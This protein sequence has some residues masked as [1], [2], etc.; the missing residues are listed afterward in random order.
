MAQ[1]LVTALLVAAVTARTAAL[2]RQG[3]K[4][5]RYNNTQALGV[6]DSTSITGSSGA[7]VRL[8]HLGDALSLRLQG[9]WTPRHG[10]NFVLHCGCH[11]DD[12]LFL[13]VDDHM[14][15][16]TQ[17]WTGWQGPAR[18]PA[19]IPLAADEPVYVRAHL[20]R[21]R[22]RPLVPVTLN[23]SLNVSG[24]LRPIP[25]TELSPLVPPL[26][27]RRMDMQR[28]L[29]SGWNSWWST[30]GAKPGFRGGMLAVAL[31]PESFA[32]TMVLCQL[33]TGTCLSE[34][35]VAG[36]LT[37]PHRVR[38]GIK[39]LRWKLCRAVGPS[40]R[41]AERLSAVE[42]AHSAGRGQHRAACEPTAQQHPTGI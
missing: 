20:H 33:S 27:Q 19:S 38:P 23:I 12:H 1:R 41:G 30:I 9:S 4:L 15:C 13:W 35:T 11:G 31:L 42:C 10:G 18:G 22:A 29:L 40:P 28:G 16:D 2:Q 34:S 25:A 17:G 39:E 6:P 24:E 8:E 5:E 7:S 21:A 14:M 37:G 36:T 26:Q 32:L 3:L